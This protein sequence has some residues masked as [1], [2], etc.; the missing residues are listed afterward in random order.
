MY[1]LTCGFS[2]VLRLF[3]KSAWIQVRRLESKFIT[4]NYYFLAFFCQ[5]QCSFSCSIGQARRNKC[6]KVKSLNCFVSFLI[7]Y[8]YLLWGLKEEVEKEWKIFPFS[9]ELRQLWLWKQWNIFGERLK[10]FST[11]LSWSWEFIYNVHIKYFLL[12]WF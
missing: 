3:L 6:L 5:L 2:E 7:F 12:K 4:A 9:Q 8:I 1:L 11:C 10:S